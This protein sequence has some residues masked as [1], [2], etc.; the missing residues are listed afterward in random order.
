MC[1]WNNHEAAGERI[2]PGRLNRTFEPRRIIMM[3]KLTQKSQEALQTA[4]ELARERSFQELDGPHLALALTQQTGT[5]VPTLLQRS[6]VDL[7]SWESDLNTELDRRAQ[8]EGVSSSDVFLSRDLKQALDRAEQAKALADD[9]LSAEHLLL[10]LLECGAVLKKLFQRQGVARAVLLEK[11]SEV[12]GSQRVTDA[13]PEDKFEAL[14]KYGKDLTALAREGKIDPVIGRNDEIRRVMQVLTRRTK[15]NPVLSEP[16]LK[17][18]VLDE[19]SRCADSLATSGL[20]RWFIDELHTVVGA[21]TAAEGAIGRA[22]TML[23]PA[24]LAARRTAL[25]RA[26]PRSTTTASTSRRTGTGTAVSTGDRRRRPSKRPSRSCAGCGALRAAPRRAHSGQRAGECRAVVQPLHRRPLPAG[27]GDRPDRRGW[28]RGCAPSSTR[29]T[30]STPLKPVRSCSWRSRR[31][32]STRK[33]MRQS[34]ERLDDL[35]KGAGREPRN[36]RR[37][38]RASGRPRRRRLMS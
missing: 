8:V 2:A 11:M 32:R 17:I 33:R 6:G 3:D 27:Q 20:W 13:N 35:Q 30:R 21:V 14:E 19:V 7:A 38:S 29:C 23:K 15:N 4:Q 10:G 34:R 25:H 24:M 5:I 26:R 1:A 9:Y 31:P 22:A 37:S 16:G 28:L 18:A 36:A 12:R